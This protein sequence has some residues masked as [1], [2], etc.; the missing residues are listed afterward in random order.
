MEQ[1]EGE[2]RQYSGRSNP[3]EQIQMTHNKTYAKMGSAL[4]EPGTTFKMSTE[5]AV[6]KTI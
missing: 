6:K 4:Q 2:K 1:N 3:K 5:S